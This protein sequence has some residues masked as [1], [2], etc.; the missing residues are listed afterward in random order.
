M[1]EPIERNHRFLKFC[2]KILVFIF[3]IKRLRKKRAIYCNYI[4]NQPIV[5]RKI[6]VL[7][8]KKTAETRGHPKYF[9]LIFSSFIT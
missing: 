6:E 7:Q 2:A 1:F 8:I 3:K 9:I 4:D 5:F